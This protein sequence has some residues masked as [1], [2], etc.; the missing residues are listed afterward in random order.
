[1]ELTKVSEEIQKRIA[2]LEKGRQLLQERAE[3]KATT[4]GLYDLE[5][6]KVI[7]KLKENHPATLVEKLAKGECYAHAIEKTLADEMYKNAIVGLQTIMSEMNAL[8]SILKYSE[9]V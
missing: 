1:M 6:S 7:L 8:Q 2:L 5:L 3:N 9:E 4:A